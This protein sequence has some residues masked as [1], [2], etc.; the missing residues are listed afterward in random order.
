MKGSKAP[1]A[2]SAMAAHSGGAI[3]V[4]ISLNQRGNHGEATASFGKLQA[5]TPAKP[6]LTQRLLFTQK[7]NQII[8]THDS[9]QLQCK[10]GQRHFCRLRWRASLKGDYLLNVHMRKSRQTDRQNCKFGQ[11]DVKSQTAKLK[12]RSNAPSLCHPQCLPPTHCWD[13]QMVP[14][15]NGFPTCNEQ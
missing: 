7:V 10:N 6:I 11:K 12:L 13:W 5:A 15:I 2:F 14:C 1:L 3:S 9:P 4:G 8:Y